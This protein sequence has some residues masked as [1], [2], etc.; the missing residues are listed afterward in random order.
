MATFV[1]DGDSFYFNGGK[2]PDYE[3]RLDVVDAPETKKAKYNKR[4]NRMGQEKLRHLFEVH[5]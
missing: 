4:D 2:T 5:D 1:T 3:C